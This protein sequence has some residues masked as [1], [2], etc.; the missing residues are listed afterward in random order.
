M[1]LS[2]WIFFDTLL[3]GINVLYVGYKLL[4]F[5]GGAYLIARLSIFFLVM[6][7]VFPIG[8]MPVGVLPLVDIHEIPRNWYWHFKLGKLAVGDLLLLLF[9]LFCFLDLVWRGHSS[10]FLFA[11]CFFVIFTFFLGVFSAFHADGNIDYINLLNAA[12]SFLIVLLFLYAGYIAGEKSIGLLSGCLW[13]TFINS[14]ISMSLLDSSYRAIRYFVPAMLQSQQFVSAIPF[15]LLY[16]WVKR[17]E[18]PMSFRHYRLWGSAAI[19]L[20]FM[21]YKAFYFL[22]VLFALIYIISKTPLMLNKGWAVTLLFLIVLLQP[23]LIYVN[24]IFGGFSAINTRAFQVIN[25]MKTLQVQGLE[26]MLFGIGWGQWYTVYFDFPTIDQGAW[27]EQ[28]LFDKS[29]K[30]SIQ[31][32][33]F[34]LIRSIGFGGFAAV[35]ILA[36][37]YVWKISGIRMPNT[38]YKYIVYGMIFLN[39]STFFSLPDVLPETAAFSAFFTGV[40]I[41]MK[42]AYGSVKYS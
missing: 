9:A 30:Y 10:K 26:S 32:L 22:L 34:S 23:L 25:A 39:V 5:N 13:F 17:H 1:K 33:P 40:M 4:S 15:L 38:N 6:F 42:N 14:L 28:Q 12:R 2:L 36:I 19:L 35:F 27:T 24:F 7:F 8:L 31:L 21:G 16:F 3:L 29:R 37:L 41:A 18:S 20:F 11:S